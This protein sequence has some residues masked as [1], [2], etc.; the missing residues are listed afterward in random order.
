[1]LSESPTSGDAGYSGNFETMLSASVATGILALNSSGAIIS[2]TAEANHL[3]SLK[4][5]K[6]PASV[7]DL[8][9]PLQ[10]II[11]ELQSS[12]RPMI[13]RRIIIKT[14]GDQ[15]V[16]LSVNGARSVLND[17]GVVLSLRSDATIAKLEQNLRRLDRLASVGT[18]SASMAHEI[19]NALVAV[20]TFTE[21]L[22]EKYPDA[23]L[24]GV[25]RRE[26]SRVDSI[27]SQMLRFA[28]PAQ[29]KFAALR[30]HQLLEH[31]L[32]LLQHGNLNKQ[33][34]VQSDLKAES[35]SLSGDDHQLE[36]AF[37]NLL[38]NAVEAIPEAGSLTVSTDLISDETHGQLRE[39]DEPS[40]RLLRIR[41]TDTGVGI[42]ADKLHRIFEPFFT[43]KPSGTGLGLAV[44]HRI[45]KEHHG[46]IHVESAPGKGT[47]FVILLPAG[48]RAR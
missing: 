13:D 19:K 2:L 6:P 27:A 31:S 28:A 16:S 39:S 24:A 5:G 21:L 7:N 46:A 11:Q 40:R 34:S 25:V 14:A 3:L 26:I 10:A 35:D 20:R 12:G 18:L 17:A 30:L 1:M 47:T 8:P 9:A 43:T 38:F 42:A 32:R 36:Q 33:I 41:I 29:P 44:T 4:S 15:P 22:L 23:D 48:E 45:I 37:L